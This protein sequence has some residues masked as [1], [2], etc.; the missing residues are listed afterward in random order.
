M[1]VIVL[2]SVLLVTIFIFLQDVS[3]ISAL[4]NGT[5]DVFVQ[6]IKGE[7]AVPAKSRTN[8]QNSALVRFWRNRDKL[9]LRGGTLCFNGN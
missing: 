8:K 2:L 4:D 7:F 9:S 3:S 5:Y 1:R 6:L